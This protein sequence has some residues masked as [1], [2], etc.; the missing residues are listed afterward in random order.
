MPTISIKLH[1]HFIFTNIWWILAIKYDFFCFW[2]FYG[3]FYL[4]EILNLARQIQTYTFIPSYLKQYQGILIWIFLLPYP[5]S[6]HSYPEKRPG[7]LSLGYWGLQG[8]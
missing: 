2:K 6:V 5:G 1:I 4:Q 3:K 7:Q 8:Q